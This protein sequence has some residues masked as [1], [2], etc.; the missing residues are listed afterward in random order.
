L[1]VTVNVGMVV[2]SEVLETGMKPENAPVISYRTDDL[3]PC[4]VFGAGACEMGV[5]PL[6]K[7]P[8]VTV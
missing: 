5:Q 7:N 3:I 1:T 8:C 4:A 6:A 2:A